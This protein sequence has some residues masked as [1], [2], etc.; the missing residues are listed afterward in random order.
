MQH[1]PKYFHSFSLLV[2]ISFM[3][4]VQLIKKPEAFFLLFLFPFLLSTYYTY[5]IHTLLLKLSSENQTFTQR[6]EK[7]QA[8]FILIS[9]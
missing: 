2:I 4:S 8:L 7:R 5:T 3:I 1:H 6:I 9:I